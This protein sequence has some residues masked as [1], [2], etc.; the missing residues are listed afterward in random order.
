MSVA[1]L[2]KGAIELQ[3]TDIV[4]RVYKDFKAEV[5]K[6]NRTGEAQASISILA[7]SPDYALI[8][9]TNWHL[10][11]LDEGNAQSGAI[12]YPK[13]ATALY[14]KDLGIARA[15]VKAYKGFHVAR[16]VADRHR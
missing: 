16:K 10:Y 6:H 13:R 9:G 14:L 11:H 7:R 5:G 12:I 15:S 1:E 8:G 2:V 3:M 4:D